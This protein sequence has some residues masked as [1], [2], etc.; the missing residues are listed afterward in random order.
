MDRNSSARAVADLDAGHLL[1]SVEVAA[2]PEQV[3]SALASRAV[4]DWWVRPGL[5]DTREWSGEVRVG[6]RWRA[7]GVAKRGPYVMDGEFLEVEPARQL[8]HTWNVAGAPGA[9]TTVTYLLERLDAGTRVTLR[10]SGFTS[11]EVCLNTCLGWETSFER[12]EESLSQVPAA[13]RA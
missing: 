4:L 7:S 1:A 9:P 2:P 5:F 10:H 3:F 12:L 8:V 13:S 11:R 6:G